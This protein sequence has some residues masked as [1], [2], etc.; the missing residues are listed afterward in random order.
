VPEW[1]PD[2]VR[3][4]READA[5]HSEIALKRREQILHAA[6]GIITEEGLQNLSLSKIEERAKMSRGQLTY[7]FP[8]KEDI[9]LGVFDRVLVMM[10]EQAKASASPLSDPAAKPW[11]RLQH[12]LEAVHTKP[13]MFPAFPILQ[14]TFLSQ[15]GHREDF[16]LRLSRLYE[17]WRDGMG[18]D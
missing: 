2:D 5:L 12:L 18:Q 1:E 9:L 11:D 10:F 15:I 3:S 13:P 16:R 4:V 17:G 6:I 14:Y 8:T 7:Y